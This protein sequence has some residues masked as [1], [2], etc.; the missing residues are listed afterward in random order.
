MGPLCFGS[1]RPLP[2][3]ALRDP[4]PAPPA[5]PLG[6]ADSLVTALPHL[7]L[8]AGRTLGPMLPA[9]VAHLA[10]RAL[11]RLSTSTLPGSRP[12]L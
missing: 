10:P 5:E 4:H 11:R 1:Q 8:C 3:Q 7:G 6:S 9:S 2:S 12:A